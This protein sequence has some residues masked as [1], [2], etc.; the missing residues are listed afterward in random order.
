MAKNKIHVDPRF[1]EG[2]ERRKQV[3][4]RI[5]DES[6]YLYGTQSQGLL[7]SDTRYDDYLKSAP[8]DK[9]LYPQI[10]ESGEI[11]R[12]E[13][14]ESQ[15][16]IGEIFSG[17]TD[18]NDHSSLIDA[19][20]MTFEK[21]YQSRYLAKINELQDI[22][23]SLDEVQEA[24][25]YK[26]KLEEVYDLEAEMNRAVDNGADER[27]VFEYQKR[28]SSAYQEL[29]NLEQDI[30][31]KWKKSDVF[32]DLF[33]NT[34]A[35]DD[36]RYT[37]DVTRAAVDLYNFGP[38]GNANY[39]GN[40]INDIFQG[41]KRLFDTYANM[42]GGI[43]SAVR[44][45]IEQ[46]SGSDKYS[47]LKRAL[48][49]SPDDT[50][51]FDHLFNSYKQHTGET[52]NHIK[53]LQSKVDDI[54]NRLE[55]EK[56]A[57]ETDVKN[58]LDI[59]KNGNWLFD[60]K[61]IDPVYR[62]MQEEDDRGIL[63]TI[64]DP[65]QWLYAAPEIG[66]SFSDLVDFAGL[67]ALN[68]GAELAASK[69]AT[70]AIMRNPY[71]RG[72]YELGVLGGGLYFS[73]E[74]RRMETNAEATDAY[75]NRII[76]EAR[77]KGIDL[78]DILQQTNEH[79]N[80]IGISTNGLNT[81]EQLQL[82][83]AYNA[84]TDNQEFN[85]LKK[86]ARK[87]IAKVV[88]ENNAL[89]FVDYLQTLPFMNYSRGILGK[90]GSNIFGKNRDILT[91]VNV[92]NKTPQLTPRI[93]QMASS[94][95]MAARKTSNG[96]IDN[97]IDKAAGKVA[98]NLATK[99][100]VARAS[101]Y[102]KNK[103][104][105][106][107][108]VGL[109]EG[110]EEGQQQLLQNRFARGEYDGYDRQVS[111]FDL[112]SVFEDAGLAFD[113]LLAYWG[114]NFSDPD[115]SDTEL[116]K[117]MN[118]GAVTG[119]MFGL[120]HTLTNVMPTDQDN[121]R[122]LVAQLRNDAV[123]RRIVA[124][125]QA[126]RQD[127][128][129][130][131]IFFDSF[132]RAGVNANRLGESLRQL[133]QF[134]GELVT[135]DDIDRDI[136]L[137]NKAWYTYKNPLVKP[138]MDD[139]G[140]KKDS[141]I[142]KLFVQQAVLKNMK[143]SD[144][145]AKGA[146]IV[147]KI[148]D[149][150]DHK[151]HAS[152]GTQE[153]A[154]ANLYAIVQ[155][156]NER[157]DKAVN[158]RI[159]DII[160][161][162]EKD[163]TPAPFRNPILRDAAEKRLKERGIDYTIADIDEEARVISQ[164]KNV[165]QDIITSNPQSFD[166]NNR[167]GFIEAYLTRIF[168][169]NLIN[170]ANKLIENLK[171][172]N[173]VNKFIK[174]LFGEDLNVDN[175]D[176]IIRYVEQQ[177]DEVLARQNE[178]LKQ[179]NDAIDAHNKVIRRQNKKRVAEG[180]DPIKE[181]EHM[182][183]KSMLKDLGEFED[184]ED[185]DKLQMLYLMNYATEQM[186]RP[187]SDA[188]MFG[189]SR[190][191]KI[192]ASIKPALWSELS[193]Q[194]RD[195]IIEQTRKRYEEEGRSDKFKGEATARTLYN[196]DVAK[197]VTKVKELVKK[198][199]EI[200]K[201]Q[202]ENPEAEASLVDID[203]LRAVSKE[204]AKLY[205]SEE[206]KR[207]QESREREREEMPVTPDEVEAA[208]NG[209]EKAAKKVA[210]AAKLMEETNVEGEPEVEF[211]EKP[212]ERKSGIQDDL[213]DE[214]GDAIAGEEF[215]KTKKKS[216]KLREKEEADRK[217]S[218]KAKMN[219]LE[220]EELTKYMIEHPDL[221]FNAFEDPL[222]FLKDY[223]IV[224]HLDE[225]K[226]GQV[227][228]YFT[229][230]INGE[231]KT[232]Y[233]IVHKRILTK[234]EENDF[235]D[236]DNPDQ[237][238]EFFTTG[239]IR[240]EVDIV[241]GSLDSYFDE[242]VDDQANLSTIGFKMP[243]GYV[244]DNGND[245]NNIDVI[246][247][248]PTDKQKHQ[249]YV[250]N[251]T[252]EGVGEYIIHKPGVDTGNAAD[253]DNSIEAGKAAEHDDNSGEDASLDSEE[254]QDD[255][256]N[257]EVE[258]K[259]KTLNVDDEDVG[260]AIE[261]E[262][263]PS[264]IHVESDGSVV[265]D[266]SPT[267]IKI[268]TNPD[269]LEVEPTDEQSLLVDMHSAFGADY[270]DYVSS[271]RGN[272]KET[273][274]KDDVGQYIES[275]F[276][277][278]PDNDEPMKLVHPDGHELTETK[279]KK[280]FL[281]GKEVMPGSEFAKKL[282]QKG[283]IDDILK[284]HRD[285]VYYVVSQH[286][287]NTDKTNP[288]GF[289]ITLCIEDGDK[290]YLSSLR[291]PEKYVWEDEDGNEVTVDGVE[292]IKSS[293]R[294][295]NIDRELFEEQ[296]ED[297]IQDAFDTTNPD[298]VGKAY[299]IKE[300]WFN[301]LPWNNPIK[302]SVI[303]Q[304]RMRSQK[305][306]GKSILSEKEMDEQIEKLRRN[307]MP[308]IE[309]Y[310]EKDPITGIYKIPAT[311]HKNTHPQNVDISNGSI[312]SGAEYHSAVEY[313]TVDAIQKAI[314]DREIR[315]GYGRGEF[316]IKRPQD[317]FTIMN[318]F[319]GEGSYHGK[320]FSGKLYLVVEGP[321]HVDAPIQM[322]EETFDT[323]KLSD[324]TVINLHRQTDN[325]QLG[326][327]LNAKGFGE[328]T[329]TTSAA[330][331]LLYLL[332]GKLSVTELPV[333]TQS[334]QRHFANLFVHY[335]GTTI[336][337]DKRATQNG[338]PEFAAKQLDFDKGVFTIGER[339]EKG[340]WHP[341]P[342]EMSEIFGNSAEQIATRKRLIYQIAE[343]MHWNTDKEDM[344]QKF[345]ADLLKALRQWFESHPKAD[346]YKLCGIDQFEF[347]K[348]DLFE[349]DKDGNIRRQKNITVLAWMLKNNKLTI[350]T[351]EQM[352][353]A[354]F[355]FADGVQDEKPQQNVVKKGKTG[356]KSAVD[357][358]AEEKAAAEIAASEANI[359]ALIAGVETKLGKGFVARTEEKKKEILDSYKDVAG[360]GDSIVDIL[361][362]DLG[363]EKFKNIE[364]V[365]AAIHKHIDNYM[366]EQNKK[367]PAD[368]QLFMSEE[369]WESVDR[370]SKL[371]LKSINNGVKMP[372]FMVTESGKNLTL[373][374]DTV[375]GIKKSASIT[376]VASIWKGRGK[377][378]ET[379]TREWI[380]R[381][382]GLD[383][384]QTIVVDGIIRST[385]D[386]DVYGLTQ[387]CCDVLDKPFGAFT[388]S[389]LAGRGIGYHEAWH[390]VNLLLHNRAQRL[391]LYRAYVAKHPELK[392]AKF[393]EIEEAMAED[394]RKY[395]EMMNERNISNV[396]KR[397]YNRF[398]DFLLSYR[399]RDL[400]R[401]VF[402]SIQN[403]D[404]VGM[405][406]DHDSLLEFKKGYQDGVAKSDFHYS[407][408]T[409]KEIDNL[410]GIND[411]HTFQ[412]VGVSL[413]NQLL[414]YYDVQTIEDLT[415][416]NSDSFLQFMQNLQR[417][418]QTE[419]N[420]RRKR[421]VNTVIKNSGAFKT[422]ADRVLKS[423]GVTPR[424]TKKGKLTK[425]ITKLIGDQE[426]GREPVAGLVNK[427]DT[428][429]NI[430]DIESI[431]VSK[432]VNV[433]FRAK[434]F[435]SQIPDS[436]YEITEVTSGTKT[437]YVKNPVIKTDDILGG[438]I[439]VPY[440]KAW[441]KVMNA[442]WQAESFGKK[443]NGKYARTSIMGMVERRKDADPFF[444]QLY[445]RL[446]QAEGDI[447]L[448]SQIFCTV[449]SSKNQIASLQLSDKKQSRATKDALEEAMREDPELEEHIK[450]RDAGSTADR[451]RV[452]DMFDDNNL[453]AKKNLPRVWS[454]SL[455]AAGMVKYHKDK[456]IIDRTFANHLYS[457]VEESKDKDA[458]S[459]V[460]M[461]EQVN[462]KLLRF[463]ND[464]SKRTYL[465]GQNDML[466]DKLKEA[467]NWM[468][469]PFDDETL[470]YY[471]QSHLST[472]SQFSDPLFKYQ[473]L[474]SIIDDGSQ[475]GGLRFFVKQ[476]QEA[477]KKGRDYFTSFNKKT[478]RPVDQLFTGY[479][480]DTEIIKMADAYNAMNP[481][482]S[483]FSVV[484][485]DGDM[486]YPISQN[487][488]MSDAIRWLNNTSGEKAFELTKDPYAKHSVILDVAKDMEYDNLSIEDMFKLDTFVGIKDTRVRRGN[489]YFGITPMEDYIA[490]M[491][492][493][494]KDRLVLPTMADKKTWYAIKFGDFATRESH[495]TPHEVMRYSE[496][497]YGGDVINIFAGY[498]KD[499]LDALKQYYSRDNIKY[500]I[501]HPGELRENFH[502]DVKN[503]RMDFSGNG[504]KFRYFYDIYKING[505]NLNEMLQFEYNRQQAIESGEYK[506]K[507]GIAWLYEDENELDGFELIR[508]FLDNV[509]QRYFGKADETQLQKPQ[510]S[511]TSDITT[512]LNNIVDSELE[513]L[514]KPGSLNMVE[515]L[516]D[517]R[518][519]SRA[520]PYQILDWYAERY[521]EKQYTDYR[522][523]AYCGDDDLDADFTLSAIT[524]NVLG[525]M[526]SVIEMEKV[527]SG[528]PAF[529]KWKYK[530][531][532]DRKKITRKVSANVQFEDGTI[533][534]FS[535]EVYILSEKH[536]DKIKRL[537]AVLS[538]GENLNTQLSEQILEE[539]P[540][541]RGTKY[542][543][544]NI[545][546]A[547]VVSE[548]IEEITGIFERSALVD[549]IRNSN[550]YS[551]KY[552][553]EELEELYS[554]EDKAKKALDE[555][556]KNDKDLYQS[557]KNSAQ[558]AVNPYAKIN[559]ADAQVIIRPALYRK[560]RIELGEWSFLEDADGYSDEAAYN[561]LEN[562]SE[563]M[564]DPEKAAIVSKLQLK[565]LKMTY[566]M[567]DPK[568]MSYAGND[569]F[570]SNMPVYN[571]MAIFPLFKYAASSTTGKQLY[572]RMNM[573]GNEL[574]MITFESAVK[575]GGH[576]NKYSPFKKNTSD[577]SSLDEALNRRSS[578]Y[579]S[580][581]DED[582]GDPKTRDAED[583]E[584]LL[585]VQIQDLNGLRLQLNTD[586][587]HNDM[588]A[589]GTQ[590]FKIAFS[591]IV[592]DAMYGDR[593]GHQIRAD[594]MSCINALTKIGVFN[595][596]DEF[597]KSRRGENG[598][599]EYKLNQRAVDRFIRRI[600][601]NNGLG[602]AAEE[603]IGNGGVVA[604]LTSRRVFENSTAATVNGEVVDINTKGGSAVQQSIFG[605]VGYGKKNVKSE[606]TVDWDKLK[607]EQGF[608]V[609]NGG[610]EL[611]WFR[612]D[613]NM[614]V[615]LS[616]NFFKSVI[617]KE[618]QTTYE[619]MRN[620]LIS[621]NIIGT[622][623]KPFG[624][625]Y[626]I[627][628]QG[629]SSMFSFVVAD[630][631]PQ[632]S[633]DLIIV[634]KEFT[635]Q[636]GSDFDVDKI[637]MAF[638]S[639]TDGVFD[640]IPDRVFNAITKTKNAFISMQDAFGDKDLDVLKDGENWDENRK[641][642]KVQNWHNAIANR[643]LG[644]YITIIKDLKNFSDARSSID[645]ITNKIGDDLLPLVRETF[646]DYRTGGYELLPS[647]QSNTKRE[648]KTGKDGI[649]PFALHIT[650][651]AMTQFTNMCM[652]YGDNEFGFGNLD[653]ILGRD[654]I[655]ISA[656][657]SA[658]VNAHVD[659]AKD[660][661]VFAINVNK[662]TYN[663]V[664]FLLRAGMGLST[665]TLMS[666]PILKRYAQLVMDSGGFYGQNIDGSTPKSNKYTGRKEKI[667]SDLLKEIKQEADTAI[668]NGVGISNGEDKLR[669]REEYTNL[670]AD[671]SSDVN[672]ADAF[673]EERA[674][675]A[676][677]NPD[678]A[679]A[680][681]FQLLALKSFKRIQKYADELSRLVHLSQIDTKKFGNNIAMMINFE[682][683]LNNFK[684]GEHGV[685]WY[686]NNEE[687]RQYMEK[688]KDDK[689][690]AARK[691]FG[692]L[693]LDDKFSNAKNFTRQILSR[694]TYM[695]TNEFD[696]V[697]KSLMQQLNGTIRV[698]ATY[699]QNDVLMHSPLDL[700]GEVKDEDYINA[701]AQAIDDIMRYRVLM[702]NGVKITNRLRRNVED[703][704]YSGPIDFTFGGDPQIIASEIERLFNG[705]PE[706]EDQ[707]SKNSVFK[708][709]AE[710]IQDIRNNGFDPKYEGL[711]DPTT[712]QINNDLLNFLLPQLPGSANEI[713]RMLLYKN[714]MAMDPDEKPSLVA[715]FDQ[716]L[717]HSNP[718]VRRVARDV[719]IFA[720]YST[721]DVSTQN[722]FFDL[723]PPYY[724]KQ[725][726]LALKMG[727][728]ASDDQL[729]ALVSGD[730]QL[731]IESDI[732]DII[733]RN[734]W[735]D[736]NIVPVYYEHKTGN[737]RSNYTELR[738]H[739]GR[740]TGKSKFSGAILTSYADN[741]YIK[742][743]KGDDVMLYKNVG[744]VTR[745]NLN[746]KD[747]ELNQRLSIYMAVPRLGYH[748]NNI[749]HYEFS[750]NEHI[751]SI[752][753]KQNS[754]STKFEQ[755]KL[756]EDIEKL[757]P[758]ESKSHIYEIVYDQH[759]PYVDTKMF[760]TDNSRNS[761]AYMNDSNN[762]RFVAANES[763][764]KKSKS[765]STVVV[766]INTEDNVKLDNR[767]G[768]QIKDSTKSIVDAIVEKIGD[769]ETP[770]IYFS[771]SDI[772]ISVT[773]KDVQ[774]YA[775][776]MVAIQESY[777]RESSVEGVSEPHI[778]EEL[779]QYRKDHQDDFKEGAKRRK[780]NH[781]LF[782]IL[783]G[784]IIEGRGRFKI[785]SVYAEGVDGVG[786]A[787]A[788]AIMLTSGEFETP[789]SGGQ[790][791]VDDK[792]KLLRNNEEFEELK[793]NFAEPDNA[794]VSAEWQ[795]QQIQS[796]KEFVEAAEDVT[797]RI[798]K[799]KDSVEEQTAETVAE[800]TKEIEEQVKPKEKP[801]NKKDAEVSLQILEES[802]KDEPGDLSVDG[803]AAPIDLG[804]M[805][806]RP[807]KNQKYHIGC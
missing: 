265:I 65:S 645:T 513:E 402:D 545:S 245:V 747:K 630:V 761:D 375:S 15:S 204:A 738:T 449:A 453:R 477:S 424:T 260:P 314:D 338:F 297:R 158:R 543:N 405:D 284:N 433:A 664:C 110:V 351:Q 386:G 778:K 469:I 641:K 736:D 365:K 621:H 407:G 466:F 572:T 156:I 604:S 571:K 139:L 248:D 644:N 199:D 780:L 586:A 617:P 765:R 426:D 594:I 9:N 588:R 268:Y 94:M 302:Q 628:T 713:G 243:K 730:D 692:S 93:E 503:G 214:I 608:P 147:G 450:S 474:R 676:L 779:A 85:K 501:E 406:I 705:I 81:L 86:E 373:Y 797:D 646:D 669:L 452:W 181:I 280:R 136:Q 21:G 120:G 447:Q 570:V 509:E 623:S 763:V 648:F 575:V 653:A 217:A 34:A 272:R 203:D 511:L 719:A 163:N 264:Q 229:K 291:T 716:L 179:I 536:T 598:N 73:S 282:A 681:V 475:P 448:E 349:L 746:K 27:T 777:I 790:L 494:F 553:E 775:D 149:N 128:E 262:P 91:S 48:K 803:E 629:M 281:G 708:N 242:P 367:R 380:K 500:L 63:K 45:T 41:T 737:I 566:F 290:V 171:N 756:V 556:K 300:K 119:M 23:D 127:A 343:N 667:Y 146:E 357:K 253:P 495:V 413:A 581:N 610:K 308:I 49:N 293:L 395:G 721:Y 361:A 376:G 118:I 12:N 322:H 87:G 226:D 498:F 116:I 768:V 499:E 464:N 42:A 650:N 286:K 348:E 161:W 706:A 400:I 75:S 663:H 438:T 387:V 724:R 685:K 728:R 679:E 170:N 294:M 83:L 752:F 10:G 368:K 476:I 502:G 160:G 729:A 250:T 321:G 355:V 720:Y 39:N 76:N 68:G 155:K 168:D 687:G 67:L 480:D 164:D 298:Q 84:P 762:L 106:F 540:E 459:L 431:E 316:N 299:F 619:N 74:M 88:N 222:N 427:E 356:A 55:R 210:G 699:M 451:N 717:R 276:F 785:R 743:V 205:I 603:I 440:G 237:F 456:A 770:T 172:K 520:I 117:A 523:S 580:K 723:V 129:H 412:Q 213:T 754:I 221:T 505:M 187:L 28:L 337:E 684:Y 202:Q 461:V 352:F 468:G 514:S 353:Y 757:V 252:D 625:G 251:T 506:S 137:M 388:F 582:Y 389:E 138:I 266:E 521:Y 17:F 804:A 358:A 209:D 457:L 662:A 665:F 71:T 616:M 342:Y 296:L 796:V 489:D 159:G 201:R 115:N 258:P 755:Q 345:N 285:G 674:K 369:Q 739:R 391:Q 303:L 198:R 254:N 683:S 108:L 335:D 228:F 289:T 180:K 793:S 359:E 696:A 133:K 661:Y 639:Y 725:Y 196:N 111:Q 791:L 794:F 244:E 420:L 410:D 518:Y 429:L 710:L 18:R 378:N 537:G 326:I 538:P 145:I 482:S 612:K 340:D 515:K 82:A 702:H 339:D 434:L 782:D 486:I 329:S 382:L 364:D 184:Q 36:P 673:N 635:A 535:T 255:S 379:R 144:T 652:D 126:Q 20:R 6:A 331:V 408:V 157:Y 125:Q 305:K 224:E 150:L 561:I 278:Q 668:T 190:P 769:N 315:M 547:K 607:D 153:E 215:E 651:M 5:A 578:V 394:F 384:S 758:K 589:I 526:M 704:S 44:G 632:Q 703:G 142:H 176:S 383:D 691:Y 441:N 143:L 327:T 792:F 573:E 636:T 643:L 121:V 760:F 312:N 690:Y 524:N 493:L 66:S 366:A 599:T 333:A 485:P 698:D 672:W 185:I 19:W 678:S 212:R 26:N 591:N 135:D 324:G 178:S 350:D 600:V 330:E 109:T 360:E 786:A 414:E 733:C 381:T 596:R 186:Q 473:A 56:V 587:H 592:E 51:T 195:E 731:G 130:V 231:D 425:D 772:D 193:Q 783:S 332:C 165:L 279:G 697:F 189:E 275:T 490:K 7:G 35:Y 97:I 114:M 576:K 390:Y 233:F 103:A 69:L 101:K 620:W 37:D 532:K 759:I 256:S 487:N 605:F 61:K 496:R 154:G 435:L 595:L 174:K 677:L 519:K 529:Y 558:D 624:V 411:Y 428:P 270:T 32:L 79:L 722:T 541:L 274:D 654:N 750:G 31:N 344:V 732:V 726:D 711:T 22:N 742:V 271:K 479:D 188:Y 40:V 530:E 660:P 800:T 695:A 583:G 638:M 627:P 47:Y 585:D 362:V 432:K 554:D 799:L 177:R 579:L 527:F 626:R 492:M 637:Y 634:P 227:L 392:N 548:Y 693:Y 525:S 257:I 112:P 60:P 805:F 741:P 169:S 53:V 307:R 105:M 273:N 269:T 439:Y 472:P 688:H 236:K 374:M 218:E 95:A 507:N 471:I 207:A 54:R 99:M 446:K 3:R 30:R 240:V 235:N 90:F 788:N 131:G 609:L 1:Q 57:K 531:D 680:K 533:K 458:P 542:T 562:D 551:S 192:M 148:N 372:V 442:L 798:Q 559:M 465:T 249:L 403:G 80:A 422:I 50:H 341:V 194:Q 510:D 399:K 437:K 287:G 385:S 787:A 567:N 396:L 417:K 751:P 4:Q 748:N 689:N 64:V 597:Y 569:P 211:H 370:L 516:E 642:L 682:N 393:K 593:T 336:M 113:A 802:K 601:E 633:G 107:G 261:V 38:T 512:F 647:F 801:K 463:K 714:S 419:R 611:K 2:N 712:G 415:A 318:L 774:D 418:N 141:D 764:I 613:G 263:T 216:K 546:D 363:T 132:S 404:Y 77:D 323:Q 14:P 517:G 151:L 565:P 397:W 734:F 306:T 70:T 455:V 102:I 522:E 421:I 371:D 416:I 781:K 560:I 140:I 649:S 173:E 555:I 16:V 707:Y 206:L 96:I 568:D 745:K 478:K 618:E 78:N 238:D 436:Y 310:C 13:E 753:R 590:M 354:P 614:E 483:D 33:T 784:V 25:D 59:Y 602:A 219:E 223:D 183:E 98:S 52:K 606:E 615:M 534:K 295:V 311:I 347:K 29:D 220:G 166:L 666:Q 460:Q 659:V 208:E 675:A 377:F 288:D 656:W 134:K 152:S 92:L 283:W 122:N 776:E 334:L 247:Y 445:E 727:L 328:V 574:D 197:T 443:I 564:R 686:I 767:I 744:Q 577:I 259:D 488:F 528:D 24:Q 557:I 467:L 481:S 124:E 234:E 89:S 320:G 563:W 700:Y 167:E 444:Y 549:A 484:G 694:Q 239:S 430:W 230:K 806:G 631:L 539:H 491:F 789:D 462:K 8:I 658:M 182:T 346:S 225:L 301:R 766:D 454:K 740:S 398:M 304:A 317:R 123:I 423:Y 715:A 11:I 795:Q 62:K 584:Q 200:I 325:L 277:Y 246:H 470:N 191:D 241:Y 657:L 313:D 401:K 72:L 292:R 100:A 309:S 701:M 735:Y 807:K 58:T 162:N 749:H 655:R 497:T 544:L 46:L 104:A 773:K 550:V 709:L 670:I 175:L 232:I 508:K 622:N 409:E 319:K 671:D 504:G 718:D 771:K 552:T 267:G 640:S 43:V